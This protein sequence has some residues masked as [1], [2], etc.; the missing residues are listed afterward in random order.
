LVEV[1]ILQ[2]AQSP[3]EYSKALRE[4]ADLYKVYVA[5]IT[6]KVKQELAAKEKEKVEKR[7]TSKAVKK[8]PRKAT[9][10]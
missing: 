3:N 4:A 7:G 10:T 1:T 6:T 2:T 5:A 9:A 8:L